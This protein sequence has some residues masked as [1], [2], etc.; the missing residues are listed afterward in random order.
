VAGM[1]HHPYHCQVAL[2][3]GKT[4]HCS[5]HLANN[6]WALVVVE[7]AVQ[8]MNLHC[9]VYLV[10]KVGPQKLLSQLIHH[11][12]LGLVVSTAT[13]VVCLDLIVMETLPVGRYS[14]VSSHPIQWLLG[15]G[16][17]DIW[18]LLYRS[19]PAF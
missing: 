10:L 8:I 6:A 4:H 5:H 18:K 9:L 7:G 3:L 19:G 12:Y 14:P 16:P 11:L 15:F 2:T 1:N 13:I 17:S